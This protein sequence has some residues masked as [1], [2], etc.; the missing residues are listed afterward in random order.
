MRASRRIH[1]SS[2]EPVVFLPKLKAPNLPASHDERGTEFSVRTLK[3]RLIT[4]KEMLEEV[5]SELKTTLA[6]T[7][8]GRM[9]QLFR[10]AGVRV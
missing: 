9:L 2:E 3:A 10:A 4:L 7:E 1:A 5:Y 8:L 6:G